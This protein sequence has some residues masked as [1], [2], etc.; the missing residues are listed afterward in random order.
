[1]QT[2]YFMFGRITIVV[3]DVGYSFLLQ[4]VRRYFRKTAELFVN[5]SDAKRYPRFLRE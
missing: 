1:M 4:L 2:I 5:H 3:P